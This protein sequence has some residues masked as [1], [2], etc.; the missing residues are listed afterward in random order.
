MTYVGSTWTN[1]SRRNTIDAGAA[2]K[3][4]RMSIY[5]RRKGIIDFDSVHYVGEGDRANKVWPPQGGA[6]PD[7]DNWSAVRKARPVD[8]LLPIG[9]R[10]IRELP[11]DVRP[12]EL[13]ARFPRIVNLIALQWNDRKRCPTYFQELLADRRGGRQ[14]FPPKVRHELSN[15]HDFW[16]R[17]GPEL[18]VSGS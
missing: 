11:A 5:G 6:H 13:A 10:W 8:V 16:Y 4:C 1:V 14:G 7:F 2:L 18:E 17:R 12:E 15:L 9:H 3:G